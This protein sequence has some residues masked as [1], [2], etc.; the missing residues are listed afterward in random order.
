MQMFRI[1]LG[2]LLY[3]AGHQIRRQSPSHIC[4]GDVGKHGSWTLLQAE[5]TGDS[6][7]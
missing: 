4:K 2:S 7:E 3:V 6:G 5:R 1:V